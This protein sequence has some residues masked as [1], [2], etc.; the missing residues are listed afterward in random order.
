MANGLDFEQALR[1]PSQLKIQAS[2]QVRRPLRYCL[3]LRAL[4]EL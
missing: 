2:P 4:N 1:D 3:G